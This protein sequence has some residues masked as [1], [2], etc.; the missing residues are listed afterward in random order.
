MVEPTESGEYRYL[1]SRERTHHFRGPVVETRSWMQ[2]HFPKEDRVFLQADYSRAPFI[3][4][5]LRR[6]PE[7]R[8]TQAAIHFYRFLYSEYDLDEPFL[9]QYLRNQEKLLEVL[10]GMAD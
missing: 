5:L 8:R 4:C 2:K 9:A 3:V 6:I 10:A 1:Y 7:E